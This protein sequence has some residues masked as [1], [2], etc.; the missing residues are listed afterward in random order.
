MN[1]MDNYQT[2]LVRCSNTLERFPFDTN[3]LAKRG[4]LLFVLGRF[5]EAAEDFKKAIELD[6]YKKDP[7]ANRSRTLMMLV[8][9][10]LKQEGK[11]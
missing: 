8:Q 6:P 10:A 7:A 2:E 5:Q 1:K 11:L 4:E 9:E 3:L